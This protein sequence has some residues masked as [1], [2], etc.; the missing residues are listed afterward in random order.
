MDDASSCSYNDIPLVSHKVSRKLS[1]GNGSDYS[2]AKTSSSQPRIPPIPLTNKNAYISTAINKVTI[3]VREV[4]KKTEPIQIFP[5]SVDDRRKIP[6]LFDQNKQ[7]Y[8][9]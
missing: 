5:I 4:V 6:S 8:F 1:K 9:T 2:T 3:N 7:P